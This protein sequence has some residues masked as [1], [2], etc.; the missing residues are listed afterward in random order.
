M[1]FDLISKVVIFGASQVGK[2]SLIIKFVD[3]IFKNKGVPTI[4]VDF[5]TKDLQIKTKTV[6]LQ[7][8][9]TSGQE[10]F[11]ERF[12]SSIYRK[13]EAF[14]L[15]YD[16]TNKDSIEEL[17]YYFKEIQENCP[18]DVV[19]VVAGNKSDL[20][21]KIDNPEEE[22]QTCCKEFFFKHFKTS[23]KNGDNI[24]ELFNY[25]ASS[26][27]LKMVTN[28]TPKST[29]TPYPIREID[30]SEFIPFDPLKDLP[31]DFIEQDHNNEPKKK[32]KSKFKKCCSVF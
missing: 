23:A 30:P 17:K 7:L 25:I 13:A 12:T 27:Y 1:S 32:I 8:W 21:S 5:R 15:V 19:I 2:T 14:I 24:N 26:V 31:P 22:L 20:D 11:R 16:L 18:K 28:P 3:D 29:F 4:G 9:D 6:R 10:V